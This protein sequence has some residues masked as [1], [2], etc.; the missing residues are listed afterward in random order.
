MSSSLKRADPA[1]RTFA[2][3]STH[4]FPVSRFMPPSTDISNP[5]LW[6]SA[7]FF[8][9]SI[10]GMHSSWNF[11]PPK[12]ALTVIMR[13]RSTL[14]R[15]LSRSCTSVG[16]LMVMPAFSPRS[17]ILSTAAI[18]SP[19]ASVWT[20]ME[21]HPALAKSSMYLTGSSI[22]RWASNGMSVQCLAHL[23]I[24]APNVRLGTNMPSMTS[25]CAQSAPLFSTLTSSSPNLEKSQD[26]MEGAIFVIAR[27][28]YLS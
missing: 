1:T 23:M 7:Q 5:G 10:L 22:I 13:T 16:G 21:S 4:L 20:V 27:S 6:S 2:P 8:T 15:Y 9:Y 3:A 28:I 12:P 11:C 24:G 18:I 25:R 26:S 17:C 19:S 14:S